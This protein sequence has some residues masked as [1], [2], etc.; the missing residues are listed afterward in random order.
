MESRKE[1]VFQAESESWRT[2]IWAPYSWWCE[3]GVCKSQLAER[4]VKGEVLRVPW[5]TSDM[6]ELGDTFSFCHLEFLI[7]G[8]VAF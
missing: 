7:F 8:R 2:Q 6:G 5:A 3:S 1:K 4:G